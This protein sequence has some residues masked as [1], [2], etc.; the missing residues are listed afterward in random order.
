MKEAVGRNTWRGFTGMKPLKP[1][2]V[3]RDWAYQALQSEIGFESLR[4]VTGLSGYANWL[5]NLDHDFQTHVETILQNA[6]IVVNPFKVCGRRLKLLNL[7]VRQ[8]CARKR[9]MRIVAF[10]HVPLDQFT[11]VGITR[12][13]RDTNYFPDGDRIR[14]IPSSCGMGFVKTEEIYDALQ[15][16][17]RRLTS[18]A[19][20]PPIAYDD[21]AWGKPHGQ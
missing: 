4:N 12:C 8:A 14:N 19:G 6:G 15:D 11:I 17:I 18:E 9:W 10:L 16:G 1:S 3:F 7:V 13:V 20:V 21:L 5:K 2:K